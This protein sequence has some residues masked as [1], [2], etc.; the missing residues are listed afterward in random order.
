MARAI[1]LCLSILLSVGP[2]HAQE[3]FYKGKTLRMIVGFTPGGSNDLWTRLIGQHIGEYIPGN[4]QV[5]VQNMPG[6]GSM[7]AANYV[8][9]VAKPDGLTLG[10]IAPAL[11]LEQLAGRKEVRFDWAKFTWIGSPERTAEVLFVRSDTPY[12]TVED[13]RL[14]AEP[15]RCGATGIGSVD[16]YFPKLLEQILGARFNVVVGYPGAAEVHMAI[17]KGEMQ[18]RTGSISSF[19]D[20]E[21]G[22]TWAK[23]GFARVL[24][25][26]GKKRDP[27]LPDVPTIY[28]LL[29]KYQASEA[30]R[31]LARVLLAPGSLGRPTV[32]GPGIPTDRVKVL[33]EAFARTMT[34]PDFLAEVRRRKYELN[35]VTGHELETI[36]REVIDQ[37]PEVIER[38][39][40]ILGK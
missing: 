3:P 8:Y 19:F 13:L 39:R 40:K 5:V 16:Y 9:S 33:R 35:P 28:E 30:T 37:R 11:Y 6:G 23:T 7:V 36:A 32:G 10:T 12:R 34:N 31:G 21:P 24:V 20:R 26:G 17:E 27:R 18:C 2:L 29:D 14:V 4:P 15:A 38:M 22:R 1:L 25:Q